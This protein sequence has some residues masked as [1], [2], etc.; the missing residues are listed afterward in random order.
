MS[1]L[2]REYQSHR[3]T[4]ARFSLRL[5]SQPSLLLGTA[6]RFLSPPL[7][8]E[9]PELIAAAKADLLFVHSPDTYEQRNGVAIAR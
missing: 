8:H 7:L 2:I 4:T 6:D 3:R 9:S 1:T 5:L